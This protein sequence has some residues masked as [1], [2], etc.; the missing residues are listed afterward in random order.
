MS[1][2]SRAL[3]RWKFVRY[4]AV[5]GTAAL[6]DLGGFLA[7][8]RLGPPVPVAAVMS[9]LIAAVFNYLASTA[10]VFR[11]PANLDHFGVFLTFGLFGLAINGSVTWFSHAQGV[12][13]LFAKMLGIGIA[14]IFNAVVNFTL[15]FGR[16]AK[17]RPTD[18]MG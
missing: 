8:L 6:I 10:F 12:S 4:V 13:P 11:Q 17:S 16:W 3:G 1:L 5:V 15:V 2:P 7:I 14:F 18:D 9:F